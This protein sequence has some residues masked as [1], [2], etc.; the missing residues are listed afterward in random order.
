MEMKEKGNLKEQRV[1]KVEK[2]IQAGI[3]PY[4]RKFER[5]LPI[6]S[7]IENFKDGGEIKIAGR[8]RAIRSHG[9][10]IF[11]D[12]EDES[13]KIQIYA[14]KDILGQEK[15]ILFQLLDVGD[16]IGLTGK[17]F[18]THMGE[19]T[20]EID[21]FIPLSK[22]LLS[23]PE[24]WHGLKD[25]EARYRQRYL[26]LIVNTK[27]REVFYKRSIIINKIREFLNARG[28]LEV[29]TPILQPVAGGAR[30]RPFE[31][32][33]NEFD[34]NLY[35]RIAPELYL[36]K[37]LV[38]GFEKVYELGRNFRNEGV[39]TRHNP[40]FTMLEVY[41]AYADYND[42]MRLTEELFIYLAKQLFGGETKFEYKDKEINLKRPFKRISF[43]QALGLDPK[44]KDLKTWKKILKDR[45]DIDI[46][47]G[48]S[49]SQIARVAEELLSPQGE[50][51][52]QPTFI[53]DYFS[54]L[55]PL[56][57]TKK[58]NPALIERFELF[59]GGMEIANAYSELNDPIEQRQRFIEQSREETEQTKDEDFIK[60]LEYGMPPAGGLG[61]GID[62]L[63]MLFTNQDSI[64]DV[65]LF[66]QL[67]PIEQKTGDRR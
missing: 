26:D 64:R 63:V 14:K 10:S 38:G 51:G 22:A 54:E 66:P 41:E 6:K 5:G 56:A 19:I 28:F 50:G 17:L 46:K 7:L 13:G 44:E 29:E 18:K 30:G 9:K 53:I 59:V 8:I 24:K 27:V 60:A 31:T 35:L 15:F 11:A 43:A 20:A 62:R 2:I 23:L 49:R 57:K 47:T 16:F 67:R 12:V 33:H 52:E 42:M 61:I 1:K 40:E 55:S 25:I 37:L 36:K 4:G 39:S 58:D 21:S 3:E 34:C 45:F 48:V 65:L 32:H